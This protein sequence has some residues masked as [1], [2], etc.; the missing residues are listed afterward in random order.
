LVKEKRFV[1]CIEFVLTMWLNTL[2]LKI[3]YYL[4]VKPL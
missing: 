2:S 4:N 1:V 3:N